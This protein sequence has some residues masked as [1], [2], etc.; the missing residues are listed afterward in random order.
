MRS[1]CAQPMN[2]VRPTVSP[3]VLKIEIVFMGEG[4]HGTDPFIVMR[5]RFDGPHGSATIGESLITHDRFCPVRLR[6]RDRLTILVACSGSR[7]TSLKKHVARAIT[8][9]GRT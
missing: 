6:A 2:A 8:P 1:R 7:P 5:F 4:V 3:S 9:T